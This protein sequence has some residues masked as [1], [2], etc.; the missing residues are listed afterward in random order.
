MDS[1]Y[2]GLRIFSTYVEVF[3]GTKYGEGDG[4]NFLHVCGGVSDTGEV[5]TYLEPFS[6][7]MWRCFHRVQPDCD[8][9]PIFSTYVEVFLEAVSS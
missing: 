1:R 2:A 9:D 7:R 6:P 5:G 4:V 3:L 8:H